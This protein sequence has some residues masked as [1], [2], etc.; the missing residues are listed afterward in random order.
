MSL[1]GF[2]FSTFMAIIHPRRSMLRVIVLW[3]ALAVPVWSSWT[4]T[5]TAGSGYLSVC[6]QVTTIFSIPICLT[7]TA[8]SSGGGPSK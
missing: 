5:W 4:P 3:A 7:P 6:G 8:W 1:V 2:I